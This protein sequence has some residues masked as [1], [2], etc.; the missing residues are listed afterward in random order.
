MEHTYTDLMS[1]YAYILDKKKD[2]DKDKKSDKKDKSDKDKK[3]KK[4]CC[5]KWKK[6]KRC[7]NCP[8]G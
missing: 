3:K 5:E 2:K 1:T 7:S 8:L 4:K 6:G